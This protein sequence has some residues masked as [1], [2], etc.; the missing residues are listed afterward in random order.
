MSEQNNKMMREY[1]SDSCRSCEFK[2][3]CTR[4]KSGRVIF[5]WEH[6]VILDEMRGR[7]KENND[8][9]QKRNC[10]SEHPFGTIK[11]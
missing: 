3:K 8:V 6:E 4:N 7:V 10:M 9:V 1:R 11:R 5:R 2:P